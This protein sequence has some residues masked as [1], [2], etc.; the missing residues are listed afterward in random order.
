MNRLKFIVLLTLAGWGVFSL[1]GCRMVQTGKSQQAEQSMTG[2]KQAYFPQRDSVPYSSPAGNET[3]DKLQYT[4]PTPYQPVRL[5]THQITQGKR[6]EGRSVRN[7]VLMIGDGMGLSQ[8]SAAW[9]ANR[10]AL[11]FDHFTHT[12]FSRTTAANRLITDSGAAGTAM[13]TGQKT[14]YHS[15]GVDTLGNR[16]PSLATLAARKGL[17]TAVVV[18]CGLTDATPAAFCSGNADRSREEDIA[19]GY[20]DCGVDFI[21]G[22][23]RV[24]FTQRAD[25]RNLLDEMAARGY[26]VATSWEATQP[27][28]SGK[29]I[30]IFQEGQIPLAAQRGDLFRKASMKAISLLSRNPRGFFAMLEGS[31][32]D[33]CGHQ[34]DIPLLVNEVA[35]FDQTIGEVLQWASNDGHTLVIVLADHETG[36]LTLLGGDLKTGFIQGHFSTKDH[37]GILVPVFAF[38]PGADNFTGVYENTAIFTKIAQLLELD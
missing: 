25:G 10:G 16:L 5:A 29:L 15:V 23:G 24:Q 27:V 4:F 12:G 34:N 32:I 13:A 14:L 11:N 36:G 20:L 18:T 26:Q 2:P 1:S 8:I 17:S 22:G 6:E 28:T 21:F 3:K 33:D 7:V 38:G 35:D 30:A 9:V 19:L 31:R 37:S